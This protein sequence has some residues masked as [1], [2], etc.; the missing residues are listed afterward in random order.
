MSSVSCQSRISGFDGSNHRFAWQTSHAPVDVVFPCLAS[1]TLS[2]VNKTSHS[3][4]Q[5]FAIDSKSCAHVAGMMFASVAS[6]GNC[7]ASQSHLKLV[8]VAI[9]SAEST[10]T[11]SFVC[12]SLMK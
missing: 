12:R 2:Y 5:I 9:F 4:S 7:G 6:S 10:L 8:M 3:S 1:V 11:L